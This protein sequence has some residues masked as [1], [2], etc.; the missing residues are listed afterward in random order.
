M[1]VQGPGGA[2]FGPAEPGETEGAG[3]DGVERAGDL[4]AADDVGA[5]DVDD[6]APADGMDGID[7][8][9]PV[10]PPDVLPQLSGAEL[11][12]E[13]TNVDVPGVGTLNIAGG[14]TNVRLPSRPG[15]PGFD[16]GPLN[17]P[18]GEVAVSAAEA[19]GV[20]RRAGG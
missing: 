20:K 7:E 1:G 11:A 19:L 17:R 8:E 10:A 2:D 4:E 16:L 5:A 18:A 9:P 14:G 3:A 6:A 13:G 15:G 12:L